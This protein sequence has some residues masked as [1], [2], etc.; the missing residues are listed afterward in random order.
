MEPA[1]T[2][3]RRCIRQKI[4]SP[5]FVSTVGDSPET[6]LDLSEIL[7]IGIRGLCFRA[8]NQLSTGDR[9]GLQLDFSDTGDSIQTSARVIW[10]EPSGLTGIRFRK[11]PRSS[12]R[13]LKQWLFLNFISAAAQYSAAQ[14]RTVASDPPATT[15][16]S[17]KPA[18]PAQGRIETNASEYAT[19]L[20][21]VAAIQ[22]EAEGCGSD[23]QAAL[24][25]LV[26][27]TRTLVCAS[28]AAIAT[29]NGVDMICRAT[30]G[31]SVPDLGA[32]IGTGASFSAECIR[33]GSLLRC[34]DSEND[35]LVDRESCRALRIRSIMA[36]PVCYGD[37]VVGLLEVFSPWPQ[38]F[39]WKDEVYL[40]HLAK[41]TLA[42]L[43]RAVRSAGATP[44]AAEILALETNPR[45]TESNPLGF[46]AASAGGASA[47]ALPSDDLG[48]GEPSSDAAP[49]SSAS[50]RSKTTTVIIVA[51]ALVLAA[52]LLIPFL[53]RRSS[54]TQNPKGSSNPGA[55][56]KKPS[57]LSTRGSQ[58]ERLR[59]QA[60]GGDPAAQFALG[61]RYATGEDVVQDYGQA[62]HWFALAAEQGHVTAQATLGAYYWLGQGVPKD[63]DKAYFWSILAKAG[64]DEGSKYR[65]PA[66][67]SHL[68]RESVIADQEQANDWIRQHQLG[69]KNTAS[70]PANSPQNSK[71]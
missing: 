62:A 11:M 52:L 8:Q 48:P 69:G 47:S 57:G 19:I 35:P 70:D 1:N 44:T 43:K 51:A 55:A 68:S 14:A 56:P 12:F 45:P 28:G 10:S 22:Q 60:Q 40:R 7:N 46:A 53:R 21:T 58:L 2:N 50:A 26:D 64:G 27:H 5:A 59:Q 29:S 63:L 61:A 31:A 67:A 4:H 71:E 39:K 16:V 34:D 42:S 6:L 25:K 65:I 36:E 33:R 24:Q 3:R 13:R 9:I 37:T 18:A 30:A 15:E 41:I 32:P 23:L 38:A 17:A 66:L 54:V 20:I 49:A